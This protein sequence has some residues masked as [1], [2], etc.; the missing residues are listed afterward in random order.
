MLRYAP[1]GST[2]DIALDVG[3]A[4]ALRV[5]SELSPTRRRSDLSTGW[6]LRGLRERVELSRGTFAAG[7]SDGYWIVEV[8]LPVDACSSLVA[9]SRPRPAAPL[10]E[11][12]PVP[13]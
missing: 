12:R 9:S 6:G 1:S 3:A 2:C 8:T 7:P 11:R 10:G 5:S 13:V 4:A